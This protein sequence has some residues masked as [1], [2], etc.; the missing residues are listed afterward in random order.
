MYGYTSYNYLLT[1]LRGLRTRKQNAYVLYDTYDTLARAVMKRKNKKRVENQN[2]KKG[3]TNASR[4]NNSLYTYSYIR[5]PTGSSTADYGY[6]QNTRTC[7]KTR[8]KHY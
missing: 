8:V 2:E 7:K 4:S 1:Y 5:R 3:R 6:V